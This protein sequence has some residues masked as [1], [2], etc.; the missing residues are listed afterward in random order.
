MTSHPA[1]WKGGG[2]LKT[3]VKHCKN[4][5]YYMQNFGIKT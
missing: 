2:V 4:I 1:Y 3:T 5:S